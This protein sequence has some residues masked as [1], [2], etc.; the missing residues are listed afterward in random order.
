[1]RAFNGLLQKLLIVALT[2]GLLS[3]CGGKEERKAKYLEKGK[4]YLAEKNY[5]KAKIEFKNVL[6]I[7]PKTA[8][9]FYHLGEI[10]EQSQNWSKAFGS[11]KKASELDPDLIGPKVSLARLYMAQASALR[12]AK[13]EEGA[14][15]AF[16]LAQEQI[17]EVLSREP[18][19]PEA[20][21]LE[22]TL[23]ASDGDMEK[24]ARQL[25]K[26]FEKDPGLQSAA[27]L[28]AGIYEREARVDEA[29]AVLLKAVESNKDSIRLKTRLSQFYG[30][31]EQND[32]AEE[33]LRSVVRENPDELSHRLTLASFLSQTDQLDKA[34]QVA[35]EAIA[36]DPDDAQ[37]YLLL[38]NFLATRRDNETA[39]HELEGFVMEKP[40]L[41]DLKFGLA[42]LYVSN[43]QVD[44][45]NQ[46]LEELVEQGGTE[47]AGLK[48]RVMLAKNIAASDPDSPRITV[49][50]DEVLAENPRDND[51]LLLKGKLALKDKDYV[52]AIASFRSVLKDQPYS[53]E[54]LQLLSMAHLENGEDELARDTLSNAIDNNP[55]KLE[56]RLAMVRLLVRENDIDRALGELDEV[57]K[58]DQYHEQALAMKYELLARKGDAAGVEEVARLMQTG[59]PEKEGGYIRE[60]RLHLAKQDY[61]AAMEVLEKVLGK[62]PDSIMALIAK[63]DVLSAQNK[64]SEALAVADRLI[65]LEPENGEGYSLKAQ[66]LEQQGDSASAI[67]FYD[68][69]LEKAPTSKNVL[70]AITRLDVATGNE[71]GAR[72]RLE[73]LISEVPDHPSANG[74]LALV[75]AKEKDQSN[76]EQAFLRQI[77]ITPKN[78]STYIQLAQTRMGAGDFDG[79]AKAFDSG[80]E[81]LPDNIKLLLG[82]AGLHERQKNFEAAIAV[83]ETILEQQPDNA[84]SINNLASLLSDHRTDEDSLG[85]AS[86]LA[87]KLEKTSQPAFLDTA[88][89]VYYRKGDYDKAAEILK[90]VVE[91][92]PQV[93]VFQYHLGMTYFKLGDKAAAS[94]H[95]TRATDTE[96]AYEGIDEARATLKML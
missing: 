82:L 40:E 42:G 30:R 18:D 71:D 96:T 22:A 52:E 80:L 17:K 53:T 59:A 20:L 92:A 91:K 32:K 68:K 16:G 15:N 49:L 79:A 56:L 29:E 33:I 25:E 85:K 35:R 81:A 63:Y 62:N 41:T 86:E 26:L 24:A 76:A 87:A 3:A 75:Y 36:G 31:H 65:Q 39:I 27:V 89:W 45:A 28:L 13:N 43:G 93:P 12:A 9:A 70:I 77:E 10:E 23:W 67:K 7:D 11:Y 72:A 37:R 64:S 51:T 38:V 73:Q 90:G 58:R 14:A 88:G 60:A 21:T 66:L 94:E 50:V 5:D 95:L 69:A 57:L 34:E 19:N 74:L 55:D 78:A 54:V 8:E 48:A 83:Y 6:Q 46:I 4:V 2:V 47:P 1:M 61:P 84:V 44:K